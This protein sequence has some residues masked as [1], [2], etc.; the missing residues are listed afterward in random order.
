MS[1]KKWTDDELISTR[2]N[3]EAWSKK[4]NSSGSGSKLWLLTAFL[5][6]FAIST[7]FAFMFF[8]GVDVMN[9]VLIIMGTITCASWYKSEKQRKDNIA[10]L[11]EINREIKARKIKDD[12]KQKS[13][14][15]S[16]STP[17]EE[18]SSEPTIPT[19]TQSTETHA[20]TAGEKPRD[21]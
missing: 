10:F 11:A 16:P 8:D 4:I 14:A 3:L 21:S 9:V 12:A 7:G 15:T 13:Q 6:A 5:G 17:I 19:E 1:M 2:D 18:N 20:A